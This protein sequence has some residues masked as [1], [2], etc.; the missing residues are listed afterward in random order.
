MIELSEKTELLMQKMFPE[1]DWPEV[2]ALLEE[3]GIDKRFSEK[4]QT[5]ES[6]ERRRF[7]ILKVSNGNID[8]LY[9]EIELSHVDFR[10]LL[11]DAGFANGLTEHEWWYREYMGIPH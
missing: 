5:P 6:L 9:S 4:E 7:A 10:D 3:E 11:M 2:R 1:A 8:W